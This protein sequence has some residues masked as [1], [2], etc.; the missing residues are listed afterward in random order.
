MEMK[1]TILLIIRGS[2][3]RAQL[4]PLNNQAVT[5]IQSVAAFFSPV[6]RQDLVEGW[7]EYTLIMILFHSI[8][9]PNQVS[10]QIG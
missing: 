2:L 6:F 1:Q 3:V 5:E 8:F 10:S 9:N 7:W 4:G